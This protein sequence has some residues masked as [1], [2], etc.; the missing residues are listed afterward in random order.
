MGL[1]YMKN[2]FSGFYS[3]DDSEM[4]SIWN[5]DKT[6]FIFDTNCLL[7]L[8]RCEEKTQNDILSVMTVIA[9]RVWI[10]FQVGLEYQRNRKKVIYES[11][12]SLQEFEESLK[13]IPDSISN[14][15][16]NGKFK[17]N[18]YSPLSGELD[19]LK[20]NIKESI[21]KYIDEKIS[22]RIQHK[23]NISKNDVVRKK[24]D[25]IIKDK[26]G[27]PFSQDDI[28]EFNVEGKN[29][30]ENKIPPGYQDE[31]L[32]D[33]DTFI[34]SSITYKRKFGDLYLWKEIIKKGNDGTVDNI[35]FVCDDLKDDWWYELKG[36]RHGA[37]Q[38]LNTEILS[39]STINKFKMITQSTFLFESK[40]YIKDIDLE[41]SSLSEVRQLQ[42]VTL[43]HY[44]SNKTIECDFKK[45]N[46]QGD[47]YFDERIGGILNEISIIKSKIEST[48]NIIHI[49]G[50]K[51]KV[52]ENTQINS[53]ILMLPGF[54]DLLFEKEMDINILQR[55]VHDGYKNNLTEKDLLLFEKTLSVYKKEI[56]EIT[57][58]I[59]NN[60]AKIVFSQ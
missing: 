21:D 22:I 59:N 47:F 28:N 35:I 53:L 20:E 36:H 27:E 19:K 24:V 58:D 12:S 9:D 7:N 48:E 46:G 15:F 13:K 18:L 4:E 38:A 25:E 50:E 14:S 6:L 52:G 41:E 29:R 37:L 45:D 54:L 56:T 17:K 49:A 51:Y 32:K 23:E 39:N 40:K 31:K 11:L 33:E 57:D 60:L 42:E 5:D 55:K 44:N 8:Y 2:I 43:S 26:V 1:L 34:F 30:F 3:L 10:P 16:L